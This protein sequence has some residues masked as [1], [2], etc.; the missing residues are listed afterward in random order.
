MKPRHEH[1]NHMRINRSVVVLIQAT[2]DYCLPACHYIQL[3]GK[4]DHICSLNGKQVLL[5]K[6]ENNY[7]RS[8]FCR[9]AEL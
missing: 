7:L 3:D 5:K 1:L 6:E 4:L 8:E 9:E 2:D